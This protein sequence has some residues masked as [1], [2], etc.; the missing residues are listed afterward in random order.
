M[1]AI[2]TSP[3]P[4]TFTLADP[5]IEPKVAT[6]FAAPLLCPVAMPEPL[7]VTTP[8]GNTLQV[9]AF[10]KSCVLP[11]VNVPS[12]DNC[13]LEPT[14]KLEFGGFTA[15]DTSAAAVTVKLAEPVTVPE[16]AV[17]LV[18][19]TPALL[20]APVAETLATVVADDDQLTA[21]V[22]SRLVPSL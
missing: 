22:R 14:A 2:D 1:T 16:V 8:A 19:P 20:A 18:V 15:S 17:M 7:T 4:V 3:D 21:L 13:S 12:A 6:T 11:S 5:L 9:T 10:D